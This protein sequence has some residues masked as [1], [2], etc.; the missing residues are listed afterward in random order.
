MI[1]KNCA[2]FKVLWLLPALIITIVVF[3][4][5]INYS[6]LTEWDDGY[7]IDEHLNLSLHNLAY[8]LTGTVQGLYTPLTSYSFMIDHNL[9]G[10]NPAGSRILNILI[11]CGSILFLTAIMKQLRISPVIAV[12]A[13]L[14][15]A[16]HPQ[17]I[18][19]VV[20]VSERKDVLAL[21]FA[22]ASLFAYIKACKN[23]QYSV[24][25]PILLLLSLGAKP[26]ALGLPV[27]ML[28]YTL[29][30][31][32]KCKWSEIKLVI[33]SFVIL[34]SYL[35]WFFYIQSI[36]KIPADYQESIPLLQKAW[37]I[38]HNA[39]WYLCSAFVPFQLN[40][41]YPQVYPFSIEYIPLICGFIF[42][43]AFFCILIFKTAFSFKLKIFL[44][45]S[46]AL[47]WGALFAPVSGIVQIGRVDYADRYNYLQSIV[48]WV[49]LVMFITR[50]PHKQCI[51]RDNFPK[52]PSLAF[53][54]VLIFYWYSSW[55][56]MPVWSS[57]ASL[58]AKAV[59]WQYPNP[60][61]VDN[62]GVTG[63]NQDN[64]KLL[65]LASG[66]YLSMATAKNNPPLCQN[67]IE[68]VIW[69]ESGLFL[70]AYAQFIKGEYAEAFKIFL[71]L[72][73][74]AQKGT[75]RFYHGNTY[76]QKLW[77]TLASCY[78]HYGKPQEAMNSLK[79]QLDVL[80]PN[81]LEALFNQGLS[82]FIN[83]DFAEAEKYWKAASKISPDD[84]KL[85]CNIKIV[86]KLQ[87]KKT[88]ELIHEK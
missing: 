24:A 67:R 30:R 38:I 19:S 79:K 78:L 61:A 25:A 40:P 52:I 13:A 49:M 54:L 36:Q 87:A 21:F 77:G 63:I 73:K 51:Y 29:W 26:A 4:P 74:K 23:K 15:W 1:E 37:I 22:L 14:L 10:H 84:E 88:S 70:G 27:V 6:F 32:R 43:S 65:E 3:A 12:A 86:Q 46:F 31:H 56:Y 16:V 35:C 42:L 9:F 41:V 34:I 50:Q 68:P 82:A 80:Q 47:C 69:L 57:S 7:Y 33:P 2:Y 81:S 39:M 62:L 59:E 55:N 8:W 58:F 53:L 11:H 83:K 45:V 5:S 85:L 66:K 20:W 64:P 72:Q 17:R 76:T 75:L 71:N 44:L 60:K 48:I 28:I 18:P